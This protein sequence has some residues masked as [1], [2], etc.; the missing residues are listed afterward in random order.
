[1]IL[2]QPQDDVPDVIKKCNYLKVYST[3]IKVR[4]IDLKTYF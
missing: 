4:N 3:K 1:M 2:K